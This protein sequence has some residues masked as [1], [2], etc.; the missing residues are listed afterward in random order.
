M[1][2]DVVMSMGS[3]MRYRVFDRR[4]C[5]GKEVSFWLLG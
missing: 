2:L 4:L 5:S 3:A 1:E